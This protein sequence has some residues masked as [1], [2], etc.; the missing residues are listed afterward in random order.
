MA[1]WCQ[2]RPSAGARLL[3][4]LSWLYGALF[5]LRS[6][7]F[8][9]GVFQT[10]PSKVPVIVVGN[11][12]AGG[13]GKTPTVIALV[14]WLQ[15][16][17]RRVGVISRGH[18][19]VDTALRL[20]TSESAP[21][22]V[23][24]E[25]LLIHL[26]TGAPVAVGRD[27]AAAVALLCRAHPPVNIIVADDGLQ[28][29]RL[30]RSVEVLLFDDRGVGNGLLLP[31][32]PL[33]QTLPSA[34]AFAG[35]V[36]YTNGQASTKLAGHTGH[37]RLVGLVPLGPWWADPKAEAQPL[38]VLVGQPVVA[39]AGLARPEAFFDMLDAAGLSVARLPLPDH[40]QLAQLPWMGTQSQVIVT[41]KDAVKLRPDR[42]GCERVWVA[43][44]DF[45][46]EPAFFTA[47]AAR[48]A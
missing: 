39:A 21:T 48:L 47:L 4:P 12:V 28:H 35:L 13:A 32:G 1:Q 18:G 42:P 3:Q 31:A 17:G 5:A 25:P 41:E 24:D 8:D 43:R 37:R 30:G 45:M 29:R 23:G 40:D 7:L 26:R 33:R 44:L 9:L 46:P 38:S 34:S 15:S 11:L 36:L 27:R 22:D 2:A 6:R 10:V 19:R 16:Q 14:T 20:V